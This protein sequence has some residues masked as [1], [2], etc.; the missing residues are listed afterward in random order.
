MSI[1][2]LEL[3][4]ANKKILEL[5]ASNRPLEEILNTLV[6]TVEAFLPGA[7][8]AVYFVVDGKLR[9][10]A[11]PN[12][13][14]EFLKVVD[15]CPIGDNH[16][17]CGTASYTGQRTI[18]TNITRDLVWGSFTDWVLSFGIQ[19]AWSNPVLSCDNEVIATVSLYY[20]DFHEPGPLDFE[21]VEAAA[22]LMAIA[23]DRKRQEELII[24][25]RLKLITSS[26][27]AALGEMAANLAHEI[28]NPLAVIQNYATYLQLAYKKGRLTF[29]ETKKTAEEIEKTV[30]RIS[31]IIK[32]LKSI[33]R[34][35][36]NDPFQEASL[37]CLIE[38]TLSF[39][40]ER[41]YQNGVLLEVGPI[42]SSI[43]VNCRSIQLSQAFL[44]LLNNAFDAIITYPEKWV[45]IEV[46]EE[47]EFCTNSFKDSGKGI[48]EL[49][50]NKIMEPFYTTKSA[51]HGTGLGL[52]IT[53]KIIESHLGN[54]KINEES[55]NTC[56]EIRLPIK[57]IL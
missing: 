45:K 9:L 20:Q 31:G 37:E 21:I 32:G 48:P 12:M 54:I 49:L 4:Y 8:A 22:N 11:A 6:K 46:K 43:V 44:N 47:E 2:S 15:G 19:S 3:L 40:R 24:E 29:D 26:K 17:V 39:C 33:S 23:V 38:E 1:A 18:S 27:L 41:F 52:S 7:Q 30:V 13:P 36:E 5:M 35:G 51:A 53:K 55:S 28:N 57:E 42:K 34:D 56:F 50:R 16:G 25:Q 10:G 14:E